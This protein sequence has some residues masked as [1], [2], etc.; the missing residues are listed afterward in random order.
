MEIFGDW[1]TV[2]ECPDCGAFSKCCIFVTIV[3]ILQQVM[4]MCTHFDDFAFN[5]HKI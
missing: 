5:K 4:V 3:M 2:K 1:P